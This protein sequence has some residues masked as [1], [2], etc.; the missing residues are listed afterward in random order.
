M[1]GLELF[2]S[3]W[4]DHFI[5]RQFEIED[6]RPAALRRSVTAKSDSLPCSLDHYSV[7]GGQRVLTHSHSESIMLCRRRQAAL[8]GMAH[9]S[10]AYG[11]LASDGAYP[12]PQPPP[13]G[14]RTAQP[15]Y[16]L[17][18]HAWHGWLRE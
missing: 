7:A 12:H 17:H 3:S 2:S 8:P 16:L 1:I 15:V 9:G 6:I 14:R 11:A 5:D 13:A 10:V 4:L 18:W